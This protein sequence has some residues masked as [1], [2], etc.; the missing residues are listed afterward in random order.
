MLNVRVPGE[1]VRRFRLDRPVMTLGRSST[2][3]LPLS[4]RTLS[5]VHARLERS[6]SGQIRVVDLG[7]RNGTT[8]NNVRITEPVTLK[9]GDRVQ[10]GETLIDVVEE[11]TTRV[12]IEGR[13]EEDSLRRTTFLQSSTDLVRRHRQET[14]QRLG[15]EELARLNASLR[16]LNEVS[17]ELLSEIPVP[18]LLELVLDK[19][20]TYL[21]PDRGLLMLADETGELKPEQVKYAE[22]VDPSD[23]RL[24]RTLVQTVVERRNG[25]L[26]IDAAT[27]G[28]LGA[29]ESIRIQ[30][31]TSCMAAP[32]FVDEKVIGL[33]YLEVR[34]GRKSFT[35]EDLRLLT[36]LANTAAI[37]IQNVRLQESA[38]AKERFEREMSVAWDIQRRLLPEREPEL[39]GTS[40]L[41]RTIP[42]RRVSGDYYDFFERPDGT[43]DVVVADVCGKGMGASILAASVQAAFQVWAGEGFPP[44]RL[45]SGLNDLIY[46]RTNPEKFITMFTVL[47]NPKS[48]LLAYTNAGHNPAL[49]VRTDGSCEL[50][51]AHGPPLGLFPGRAYGAG[52][53][54][55]SPGDL[56]VLYTDGI[57]E[58]SDPADEE[59]GTERL[60]QVVRESRQKPVKEI[61]VDVLASLASFVRGVPYAD[62][63]TFVLLRR[64]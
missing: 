43:V 1:P 57:T 25:V 42:S 5:R 60:I 26:V 12:V 19:V 44:D 58:A 28:K 29:A 7:S 51:K 9:P 48:G 46:R 54:T 38:A 10:L 33:I 6:D 23:I 49:L 30:G 35:E 20:F 63:R 40:I 64:D 15:A 61:E 17:V 55:L 8:V 36:S 62:D 32:L 4:D 59:F 22:G 52:S 18:K 41:G 24:S 50:L 21:Q 47:Y 14:D 13:D 31:V 56:V 34:L 16:I 3:D 2:N 37:K 11:S 53:L 27:D 39:P 45:C